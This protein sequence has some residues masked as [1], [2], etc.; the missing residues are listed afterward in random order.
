MRRAFETTLFPEA[1]TLCGKVRLILSL[2]QGLS[3]IDEFHELV[4]IKSERMQLLTKEKTELVA[5]LKIDE[6]ENL[7]NN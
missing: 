2:I 4:S 6:A 5:Q 7:S 1:L 3:E